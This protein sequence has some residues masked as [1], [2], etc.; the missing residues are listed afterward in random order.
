METTKIP[1]EKRAGARLLASRCLSALL[2]ACLVVAYAPGLAYASELA[3]QATGSGTY[4]SGSGWTITYDYD[5]SL[6]T[7]TGFDAGSS[8]GAVTLSSFR[9]SS[10]YYVAAVADEAFSGATGL[11]SLTISSAYFE[12]IGDY[13]FYGCTSL[14]GSV[15][16]PE[17]V[18]TLGASSFR[19]CTSLESVSIPSTLQ[20]L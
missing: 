13:A 17:G 5:G 7:I 3:P 11:T 8:D 18:E 6:A 10:M 16:I 1:R 14:S 2:S 19:N 12:S 20:Y 15:D 9:K 4:E